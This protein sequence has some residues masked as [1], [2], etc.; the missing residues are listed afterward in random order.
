MS[1]ELTDNQVA[2]KSLKALDKQ[3]QEDP[4]LANDVS[5]HLIVNTEKRIG[6]RN[7]YIPRL[8]P[9]SD[10]R[11]K[12]CS[13]LKILLICKDPSEFYRNTLVNDDITSD[14]FK[15]IIGLKK[16][17]QRYRGKKLKELY[18]N[19]DLVVSDYRVHHLLPDILGSSF[20]HSKKKLPFM[21]RMSKQIKEKG[22]K[23]KEECDPKYVRAQIR[24]IC[25]NTWYVPNKDNC[26]SIKIGELGVHDFD[27]VL[28]NAQDVIEF[29]CDKNKR[30]QGGCLSKTGV[31]SLFIKTSN[32]ISLPIWNKPDLSKS[33]DEED[34]RL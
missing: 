12:K 25:K 19:F 8:I 22:L 18:N 34:I 3:C 13:D 32:S 23:M 10:G 2:L 28:S 1:I 16:L 4:K 9:L 14:M 17:R 20:Y 21:I 33:D 15:E 5:I 26:L 24:S 29:L 11:M 30:P 31:S 7:D 27:Q 6:I